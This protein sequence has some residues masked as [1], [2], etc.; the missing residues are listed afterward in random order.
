[1]QGGA[2]RPVGLR[3]VGLWIAE[4]GL[5]D[6]AA[7]HL[8]NDA[9]RRQ[10][11]EA[12]DLDRGYHPVVQA[13]QEVGRHDSDTQT[14]QQGENETARQPRRGWRD[15]QLGLVDHEDIVGPHAAG[16]VD[17][18][19][20][21]QQVVVDRAVGVDLALQ[22]IVLD[23]A[24]LQVQRLLAQAL[25]APLHLRLLAQR[26]F[27]GGLERGLDGLDLARQLAVDLLDLVVDLDHG[28]IPRLERL[29]LLLV[30]RGQHVAPAAQ[31]VDGAVG[32]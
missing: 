9:E 5:D 24:P 27:V 19:G 22:N 12:L 20:A 1:M 8:G 21:L 16:N 29:Q 15:R 10:A 4:L 3:D 25:D 14:R 7:G 17:L 30:L 13:L 11:G 26:R 2:E 18:L 32:Q 23:A 6:L 31:T 28:R